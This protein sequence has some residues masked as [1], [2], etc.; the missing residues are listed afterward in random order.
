M[1]IILSFK[2]VGL[3]LFDSLP[4]IPFFSFTILGDFFFK[5][6]WVSKFF[7]TFILNDFHGRTFLD[8]LNVGNFG[9]QVDLTNFV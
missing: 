4:R 8:F 6:Q 2:L 1:S 9:V 3:I 7:L 5:L